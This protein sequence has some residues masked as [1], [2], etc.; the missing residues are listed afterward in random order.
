MNQF[1]HIIAY[2]VNLIGYILFFVVSSSKETTRYDF[3]IIFNVLWAIPFTAYLVFMFLYGCGGLDVF[4]TTGN[5]R[6]GAK[7]FWSYKTGCLVTV[8]YPI[9]NWEYTS[10]ITFRRFAYDRFNKPGNF[11]KSVQA[12]NL[13]KKVPGISILP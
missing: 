13:P 3:L 12:G 5:Y 4:K 9:D 6:I 11:V 8:H 10:S 1:L 2:L 7:Q